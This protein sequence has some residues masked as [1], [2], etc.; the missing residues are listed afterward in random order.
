MVAKRTGHARSQART[1]DDV[2][3]GLAVILAVK[4]KHPNKPKTDIRGK[5]PCPCCGKG[6]L[7]YSISSY[8]GHVWAV[9]SEKC[10][11]VMQ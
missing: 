10:V 3:R 2:P 11:A 7:T 5:M 9:C 6:T 1:D 4:A 8:N